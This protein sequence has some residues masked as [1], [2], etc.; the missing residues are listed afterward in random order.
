N[1][2][3]ERII[4]VGNG[5]VGHRLCEKLATSGAADRFLV[6]VLGEERH[7]AYDRVHLTDHFTSSPPDALQLADPAWFATHGFDLRRGVRG[8]GIAR[9]ECAIETSSGERISYD[10]L[11][12]A[13]G[14]APFVPR[15]PGADLGSVFVYRTLDDLD[16]I[17]ARAETASRCV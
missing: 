17:R 15:L 12:L 6:T 2:N 4:V 3:K 10:R 9:D 8:V 13:T 5:M 16:A 11:I 14:S 7:A 1:R